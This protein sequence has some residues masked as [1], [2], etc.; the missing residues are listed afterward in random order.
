MHLLPTLLVAGLLCVAAP[1]IQQAFQPPSAAPHARRLL[2]LGHAGSG[3]FT[4]IN[5]FNALPPSSL[6][7]IQR[8]LARGADGVE[9]DIQL[10]QDSIPVL[11]HDQTLASMT[12]GT[13]CV[14]QLSA[15]ALT[16][17]HYRG[18]WPYDWLQHEQPIAL[19]T[20]LA[21]LAKRRSYPHLHLDLHELDECAPDGAGYARS[22]ALVR[23]LIR[24]LK[25]YNVPREK[26]LILTNRVETLRLF[27]AQLPAAALALEITE[28]F[29]QGLPVAVAEHLQGVV[30]RKDVA[31]PERVTK[32]QQAGLQVVIFGGRSGKTLDRLLAC[33]PDA[34][35]V[36]NLEGLLTKLGRPTSEEER[37][38]ATADAD[39]DDESEAEVEAEAK[40]QID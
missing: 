8:A 4:P 1:T 16:R 22:P 34:I 3:F 37:L 23:A 5:P 12:D 2:V 13:G 30:I 35:E 9:V 20:L 39:V 6:G 31:T 27:R 10:S 21:T 15:A 32:A 7:G 14:S 19:E 25:Q 18:G 36:D 11:Y 24:A 28:D 17:L 26:V 29:D 38:P 33:H 40:H